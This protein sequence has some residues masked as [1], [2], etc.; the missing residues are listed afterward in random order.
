[1][2]VAHLPRALA[3]ALATLGLASTVQA[4]VVMPPQTAGLAEPGTYTYSGWCMDCESDATAVV[5]VTGSD[6]SSWTFDYVS[7]L[8]GQVSFQVLAWTGSLSAA[9]SG[10]AAV[11]FLLQTAEPLTID[12][13]W[14][15]PV[16]S[17]RWTFTTGLPME[18]ENGFDLS[19]FTLQAGMAEDVADVGRSG[20][21]SAASAQPVPE[22]SSFALAGLA[23]AGLALAT[24]RRQPH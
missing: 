19:G 21:W 24:R 14:Y 3:L 7:A 12:S 15:A 8:A 23:L 11:S 20:S 17:T 9:M 16:T 2:S 6:T 1:M 4:T 22:P 5:T 10:D 18:T 13:P